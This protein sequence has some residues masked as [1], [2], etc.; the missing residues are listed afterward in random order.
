MQTI[1]VSE[2]VMSLLNKECHLGETADELLKR[3]LITDKQPPIAEIDSIP[4]KGQQNSVSGAEA[5]EF[6]LAAAEQLAKKLGAKPVADD[7]ANLFTLDGLTV[8]IKT[9]RT[10]RGVISI[11]QNVFER[12]D[13][14]LAAIVTADPHIFDVYSLSR[15][16]A[17]R[18]A[19]IGSSKQGT[20]QR[21]LSL[22][23]VRRNG[24]VLDTVRLELS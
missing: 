2:E 20:P 3:L 11:P 12:F 21:R 23:K 19:Y 16:E 13:T 1:Q 10:R 14:L 18:M 5:C 22:A 9:R 17:L 7:P 6:G 8:L 15:D 24:S 4:G